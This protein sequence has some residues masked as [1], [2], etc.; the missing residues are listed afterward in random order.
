MVV[1]SISNV[2]LLVP[3]EPVGEATGV[4]FG[5]NSRRIRV[6]AKGVRDVI[7]IPPVMIDSPSRTPKPLSGIESV[8]D[9]LPAGAAGCESTTKV[10]PAPSSKSLATV[11]P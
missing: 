5:M 1:P 3:V 2:A 4:A 11:I 9:A 10:T 8:L 6:S 7:G